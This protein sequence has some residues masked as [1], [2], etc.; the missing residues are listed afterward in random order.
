MRVWEK[1]KYCSLRCLARARLAYVRALL[2]MISTVFLLHLASSVDSSPAFARRDPQDIVRLICGKNPAPQLVVYA[3]GGGANLAPYLLT[4]PGAS[5]A[6]LEVRVPYSRQSLIDILGHEP[7]SYASERVA[8]D[9]AMAAFNR[10]CELSDDAMDPVIRERAIGLGCTAALRSEPEKAGP[11]RCYIAVQTATGLHEV[12]ITLAKGTRSRTL[13]DVV[14][15]RL[16][17]V[18]LA[19]A[20]EIDGVPRPEQASE[21]W[22]LPADTDEE[23][24][25]EEVVEYSFRDV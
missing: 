12:G 22:Q 24:Q 20:C 2:E 18:A 3:T 19:H 15:S 11:H 6:V 21:F 7:E 8:R 1:K 14:V 16:A 4:T 13:E 17:L 23:A 25:D 9:M 5:R 10:A